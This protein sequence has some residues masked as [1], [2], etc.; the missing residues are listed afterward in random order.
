MH[1]PEDEEQ[2]EAEN[3][4]PLHG[5]VQHVHGGPG[6]GATGPRETQWTGEGPLGEARRDE[7]TPCVKVMIGA[8]G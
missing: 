7:P 2:D 4:E 1:E 5:E 3:G 6:G 8:S